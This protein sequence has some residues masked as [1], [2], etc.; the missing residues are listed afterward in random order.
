MTVQSFVQVLMT[1]YCMLLF[2]HTAVLE[3][4]NL[5]IQHCPMTLTQGEA[6]RLYC[7][8]QRQGPHAVNN[9]CLRSALSASAVFCTATDS[10]GK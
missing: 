2:V 4:T 9:N 8:L 5:C 1:L 10:V 6:E 7:T 3:S